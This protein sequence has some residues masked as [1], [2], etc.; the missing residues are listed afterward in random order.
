MKKV[1]LDPKVSILVDDI[2]SREKLIPGAN[3]H[4]PLFEHVIKFK[5]HNV[6]VRVVNSSPPFI[7]VFLQLDNYEMPIEKESR[8][9][10]KK[11]NFEYDGVDYSFQISR[12]K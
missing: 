11:Y 10:Y 9:L 3:E 6:I 7:N 1:K 4:T 2:L 12:T 5:K 8:S